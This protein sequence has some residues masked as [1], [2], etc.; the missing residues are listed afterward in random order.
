[1]NTHPTVVTSEDF[2]RALEAAGLIGSLL[3]IEDITIRLRAG[4][5][6]TIETTQ[7]GDD[8]LYG[9]VATLGGT[10]AE[11]PEEGPPRPMPAE[12]AE[13]IRTASW[14]LLDGESAP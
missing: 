8:R 14:Q 6:V 4:N 7:V 11:G 3:H 13:A 10:S 2:A 5:L 9:L 12:L 1:M